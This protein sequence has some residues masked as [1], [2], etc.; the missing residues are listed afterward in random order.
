VQRAALARWAARV[1]A[2]LAARATARRH[3]LQAGWRK[4]SSLLSTGQLRAASGAAAR[5]AASRRAIARAAAPR[6]AALARRAALRPALCAWVRHQRRAVRLQPARVAALAT[7]VWLR[8]WA[9]R[10]SGSG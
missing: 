3:R 2:E 5:G 7:R 10:G 4:L 6:A 9:A 8:R 1:R